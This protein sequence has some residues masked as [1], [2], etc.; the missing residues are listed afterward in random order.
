MKEKRKN[1][2]KPSCEWKGSESHTAEEKLTRFLN[3]ELKPS[4]PFV[5]HPR[6]RLDG[7]CS[8][9][10]GGRTISVSQDTPIG[11]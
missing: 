10:K 6:P 9:E 5:I 7:D 11:C 8:A 1:D 4:P 3:Q 2:R